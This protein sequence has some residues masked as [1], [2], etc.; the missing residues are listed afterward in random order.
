[1]RLTKITSS[2]GPK[3]ESA[4]SIQKLMDAGVSMFRLNFSHDT[5]DSQ[6]ARIKTIRSFGKPVAIVA[7]MQGPKNRIACF[8]GGSTTLVAGETFVFDND[9]KLGDNTRVFLPDANV[10]ASLSVGD[11]ILLNDGKQ[12][13]TVTETNGT[14]VT[15]KIIRGGTIKD[16]RRNKCIC[17]DRK[18][19][20]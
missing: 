8:E 19:S 18:R 12:E 5:G 13:F 6:G 10:L 2:I 4:D 11:T 1:M 9:S 14:K 20:C 7:D 16:K 3:S 17:S 15:A